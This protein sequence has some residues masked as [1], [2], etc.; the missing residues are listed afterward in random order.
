MRIIFVL[1]CSTF[2]THSRSFLLPKHKEVVIHTLPLK[3][4]LWIELYLIDTWCKY[5]ESFE[6][7]H[8]KEVPSIRRDTLTSSFT[9]SSVGRHVCMPA[10]RHNPSHVS[11]VGL[12]F[13]HLDIPRIPLVWGIQSSP[14]ITTLLCFRGFR[15]SQELGTIS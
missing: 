9:S 12:E 5:K 7:L 14:W 2:F 3:I 1:T 4:L 6:H 8:Q 15:W 13:S 11:W 10:E